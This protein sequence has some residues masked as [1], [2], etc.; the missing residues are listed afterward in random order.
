MRI[1]KTLVT[2]S[3]VAVVAL[4]AAPASHAASKPKPKPVKP[5]CN[6]LTDPTGDASLQAPIPTDD[7]LDIVSADVATSAKTIS[8]QLRLKG[9]SATDFSAPLG[10]NYYVL[11]SAPGQS[12]PI[13]MSYES[14]PSGSAYS[15]GT[16]VTSAGQGSFTS[17]KAA[18]DA[19]GSIV[20]NN[21]TINVPLSSMAELA[22]IKPGVKITDLHAETTAAAVVLVFTVDDATGGKTYVAG[23]PS[24]VKPTP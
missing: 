24:C 8:V 7:S 10:R 14:D 18:K 23:T 1:S 9:Y 5:V 3:A 19:T 13:Y 17:A 6:L 22:T 16:L 11:F 4:V 2:A 12:N 20:G 21:I 15:F